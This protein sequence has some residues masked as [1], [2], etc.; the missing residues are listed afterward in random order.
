VADNLVRLALIVRSPLRFKIAFSIEVLV[1]K[2]R[3]PLLDFYPDDLKEDEV[4]AR[5]KRNVIILLVLL[6][7][8]A[9]LTHLSFPPPKSRQKNNSIEHVQ[10]NQ[11][12]EKV[13]CV[14]GVIFKCIGQSNTSNPSEN[15]TNNG[16]GLAYQ[17]LSAQQGMWR[18]TNALAFLTIFSTAFAGI[19]MYFLYKTMKATDATLSQA[20]K[21][22]KATRKAMIN[23]KESNR[24][25][26]AA[27]DI[28]HEL[29]R[30]ISTPPEAG[31]RVFEQ[32][33]TFTI[34]NIG[35]GTAFCQAV[36]CGGKK[37]SGEKEPSIGESEWPGDTEIIDIFPARNDASTERIAEIKLSDHFPESTSKDSYFAW[38]VIDYADVYGTNRRSTSTFINDGGSDGTLKFRKHGFTD[39]PV[40]NSS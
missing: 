25:Q 21:T 33:F 30:T 36:K 7:T 22:T 34:D 24:G 3:R 10:Q 29:K 38:C 5:F 39:K 16:D 19:A 23:A 12:E 9:V 17:D 31:L 37:T 2:K 35:A 28:S 27:I 18:A 20:R 15:N 13:D 40:K 4:E 8:I 32:Q 26:M 11:I 6:I 14:F 1:V